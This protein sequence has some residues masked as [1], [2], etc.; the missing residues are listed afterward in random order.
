MRRS[1]PLTVSEVYLE[2]PTPSL[3]PVSSCLFFFSSPPPPPRYYF[4]L[5]LFYQLLFSSSF[6]FEPFNQR[7]FDKY[8][9]LVPCSPDLPR[10]S[11]PATY[12]GSSNWTP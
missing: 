5:R 9:P 10:A 1:L 11:A 4:L 8:Q 12:T 7:Q 3:L 6:M 2:T